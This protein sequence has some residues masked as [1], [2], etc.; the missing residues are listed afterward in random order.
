[1][2]SSALLLS[3]PHQHSQSDA[4]TTATHARL[5]PLPWS[6]RALDITCIVL[7][8]PILIPWC[9]LIAGWIKCRSAGPVLFR[10]ERVGYRG[11][12]FTCFKFRSMLAGANTG[13]HER[14]W[15]QL[16]SA[17]LPMVKLDARGDQRLIPGGR[18]LRAS[19]LDEL[20]QL[21]NVLRGEMSLVG[22][23]PCIPYESE[24]YLPWQQERFDAVP[25]LTGLWQVSGKSKT[26]VDEMMHLDIHYARNRSFR[27]DITILFKTLPAVT[28]QIRGTVQQKAARGSVESRNARSIPSVEVARAL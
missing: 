21:L 7:A 19:G 8:M 25:G 11:R 22:P 6:K 15:Q 18:L 4:P 12:R 1:M 20:P 27:L 24:Q 28:D 3:A 14:H 26:T 13:V 17:G 16:I 2:N 9:L 5:E 23:R 10:Q